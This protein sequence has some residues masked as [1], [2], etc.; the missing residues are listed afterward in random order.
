MNHRPTCLERA[1]LLAE[2]GTCGT[3]MGV[4][5]QLKAE[6]YAHGQISGG[7]VRNQLLKLIAARKAKGS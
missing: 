2:S 5:R 4:R 7:T 6:G 3:L 1:F